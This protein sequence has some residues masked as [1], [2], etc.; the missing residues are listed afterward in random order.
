MNQQPS[1]IAGKIQRCLRCGMPETS[2]RIDFDELN[3]CKACR[4]S[5]QKMRINWAERERKLRAI[6]D[7]YRSAAGNNYDCMIPISG[8]KDSL[9]QLFLLTKVYGLKPLA[10]TFSH[11][12]YTEVGRRNLRNG[13]DRLNIDHIEFTPGRGLVNHLARESLGAIGD[14][15]WHCHMGVDAFPMQMAVRFNIPLLVYGES[16]AEHSGKATY[17]D[18]PEYTVDYFLKYSAKAQPKVMMCN[19]IGEKDLS[20]FQWPTEEAIRNL[21]LVRIHLGDFIFWDAERQTEFVRDMLGWEEDDVEGT[22]KRY[23][24]VECI[25]PGVHDYTKYLKRGFGRGTDFAVQDVRSGLLTREQGFDLAAENDPVR[26]KVMD[27]Y[28]KITGFTEDHLEQTIASLREEKAAVTLPHP[29]AMKVVGDRPV[30]SSVRRAVESADTELAWQRKINGLQVERL[31]PSFAKN[32]ERFAALK[33]SAR[34]NPFAPIGAL[35]DLHL[36][37]ASESASAIRTGKLRATEL[38]EA[39][40]H[41]IKTLEPNVRAWQAFDPDILRTQA[42]LVDKAIAEGKEIGPLAGVPIG[43][44]DVFNTADYPTEMGS[45]AWNGFMPGNDARAVFD[46]RGAGAL[47]AGKTVTAEFAIHSPGPT[48]NPYDKTR[49]PGTSSSGSAAAVATRMVPL[50]LGTQ[51]AGSTIRPASYCG[52]YGMKP[53]FGLIPRTG[54]LKTTDTLDHVS[55]FSLSVTDLRLM[56]DT[57]RVKGQ[58]YPFV[59]RELENPDLQRR[60]DK[61][62]RVGLARTHTWE[63]AAD[64]THD[65][66][67]AFAQS[68]RRAGHS[69]VELSLPDVLAESHDVHATLYDRSI[70]YY[71]KEEYANSREHLSPSVIDMIERGQA[72]G[73]HQFEAALQRQSEVETAVQSLFEGCD[74]VL[75][76]AT[77]GIA[78]PGLDSREPNDPSLIWTLGRTPAISLPVATGPHGMPLG[79]QVV[80]QR[81]RDY[82]LLQFC[83]DLVEAGIAPAVAPMPPT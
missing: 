13:L 42:W 41:R 75:S 66:I 32:S 9:F 5:E 4:S 27:Y 12:W 25:M 30:N 48:T 28:L 17:L 52:V 29:T 59:K 63:L 38:A 70:A 23:K 39:Y 57:L 7:R 20:L 60:P 2:D 40:I 58:N 83:A 43:I 6:F 51:T 67:E 8:G 50:A 73:L 16:I 62:W 69:I 21:G 14:A 71:F 37:T 56:L 55:F 1:P 47:I 74:I 24:S 61:P 78:L 54:I 65:A 81:Y 68:L 64:Y 19:G 3:I 79:L 18:N 22:F 31:W 82:R 45:S 46:L 11:N 77:A 34:Q 26:P 33:E 53:S 44:K 35:R 76:H 15:C 80:G 72:I 10:V 49:T 36:L